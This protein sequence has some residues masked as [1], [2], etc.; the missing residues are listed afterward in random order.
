MANISITINVPDAILPLVQDAAAEAG[1]TVP[2]LLA[3]RLTNGQ[4]VQ[5]IANDRAQQAFWRLMSRSE[6]PAEVLAES[7]AALPQAA[8]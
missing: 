1:Q 4:S 8:A 3:A 7:Q 6:I 2:D 5:S